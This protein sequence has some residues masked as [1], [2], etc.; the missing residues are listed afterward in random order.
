MNRTPCRW[1]S[2][3]S[4]KSQSG[5]LGPTGQG[6][7]AAAQGIPAGVST[8]YTWGLRLLGPR[9]IPLGKGTALTVARRWR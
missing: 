2:A 5:H 1:S 3:L 9:P 7:E 6:H 8:P 4:A